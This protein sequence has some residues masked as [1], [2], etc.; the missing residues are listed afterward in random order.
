MLGANPTSP[1]L[2]EEGVESA[3]RFVSTHPY[4]P[5]LSNRSTKAGTIFVAGP[6]S[7]S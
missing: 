2:R 1:N 6:Y 7:A 3:A 5:S 4:N